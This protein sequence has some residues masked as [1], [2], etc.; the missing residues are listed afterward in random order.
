MKK[1]KVKIWPLFTIIILICAVFG[2]LHFFKGYFVKKDTEE[3]TPKVLEKKE[4]EKVYNVSFTLA[5]NVLV[6]SNMWIDT[7]SAEGY[8]FD[9]IFKTFEDAYKKSNINFYF[10]QSI[11]GG[12][13]L[14]AS[15]IYDYNT[16]KEL[17]KEVSKLGFNLISLGSYHAYDRGIDGIKN[18]ITYLND[19]KIK[20][21]GIS[22]SKD[23][24]QDNIIIKN[25]VK[26]GLL[27]YAIKTDEPVTE[28]Y[29]VKI[30]S[31]ETA[32]NDVE[33]LK[34]KVDVVIV[35]IDWGNLTSN[36]VTAEQKRIVEYLSNL[37][38]NIIVGDTS[39]SIQPIEIINNTLVC[40]S[41][42]NLLS[43]HSSIDSRI[44]S[45]V[46][47]NLK[48]TKLGDKVTMDFEKINVM[49][50]YAYNDE[51]TQYKIVPFTKI[52]KELGSYKTYY[53]KYNK[54]LTE[55]ND[56][57]KLYEIGE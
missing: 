37:G 4:T 35:S 30:Y 50:T 45:V 17:L 15:V 14:G 57:I 25:G 1:R 46:D 49:L 55:N 47:F 8:D 12:E 13:N 24:I 34:S 56:K 6:N 26:V 5:G 27:S 32:K 9:V 28:E 51:G 3:N 40:Y 43:G 22:D 38:V 23:E 16:P 18:T 10:E 48:I 33:S 39:Y 36:D 41:L 44:S 53:E 2:V 29:A 42:G 20:Y 52:Q 19:N 11:V 54:L 31:D 7:K 21:S